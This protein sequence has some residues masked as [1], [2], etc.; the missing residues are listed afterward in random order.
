MIV[1]PPIVRDPELA[2]LAKSTRFFPDHDLLS[3]CGVD[4]AY[5]HA[6]LAKVPPHGKPKLLEFFRLHDEHLPRCGGGLVFRGESFTGKTH[7]GVLVGIFS[8]L[9][10]RSFFFTTAAE[11]PGYYREHESSFSK[12]NIDNWGRMENCKTLVIDNINP[13]ALESDKKFPI[14][15]LLGLISRRLDR[16]LV[17]VLILS[18]EYNR[19]TPEV[20]YRPI[21]GRV[22]L[23]RFS[24]APPEILNPLTDTNSSFLD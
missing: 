8:L 11:V 5:H 21:V 20:L 4:E 16:P 10:Y 18:A 3:A 17:T 2:A 22:E 19:K 24:E 13:L 14:L 6:L 1:K 15:P 12:T 7:A 9:K 23:I